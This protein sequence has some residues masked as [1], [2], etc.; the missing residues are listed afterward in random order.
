[1]IALVA[2]RVKTRGT[3]VGK[4]DCLYLPSDSW[5]RNSGEGRNTVLKHVIGRK[6]RA[7]AKLTATEPTIKR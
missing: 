6:T 5:K 7:W 4:F 3:V 2:N 1:M